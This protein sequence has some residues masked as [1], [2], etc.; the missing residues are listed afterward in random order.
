MMKQEKLGG[1]VNLFHS[2]REIVRA[3]KVLSGNVT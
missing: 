1:G 3:F 2:D